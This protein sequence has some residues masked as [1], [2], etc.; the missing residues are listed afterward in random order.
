GGGGEAAEAAADEGAAEAG[1]EPAGEAAA[2]AG[3]PAAAP[4]GA[5]G[6]KRGAPSSDAPSSDAAASPAAKKARPSASSSSAVNNLPKLSPSVVVPPSLSAN[7]SLL[8]AAILPRLQR[9]PIG[10]QN[11]VLRELE[12]AMQES[13]T[14]RTVI[15]NETAYFNGITNKFLRRA[16]LIDG[17]P[18]RGGGPGGPGAPPPNH[19]GGA[20]RDS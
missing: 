13:K 16:G 20:G 1:A 18:G 4:A 8:T 11:A 5:A 12:E 7:P 6:A 17:P 10:E 3:A 19:Y 15:K 9:L 2:E 14:G